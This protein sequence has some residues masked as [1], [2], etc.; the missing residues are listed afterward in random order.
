MKKKFIIF[1]LILASILHFGAFV[2]Y[3]FRPEE[4]QGQRDIHWVSAAVFWLLFLEV[5]R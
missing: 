5:E 3:I 1:P 2:Y 4:Y